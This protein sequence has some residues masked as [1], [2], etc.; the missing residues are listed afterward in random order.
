MTSAAA[1][2]KTVLVAADRVFVRDRF[3]TALETAGHQAVIVK[4]VAQ[5]LASVHADLDDLDLLVLDLRM[6]HASGVELI[7]RIR[8][9]DQGHLPILVFSGTVSSAEEVR[10][11]AALGVSGYLNEYAAVEHILPSIAPHLFPD[12]FNRRGGPRVVMGIPVSYRAGGTIAA[13]LS[14]NLSRGGIAIRTSAPLP[15]DTTLKLHFALPGSRKELETEGIVCWSHEKAGM[16]LRFTS[17]KPEDQADIND[18][19]DAHFFRDVNSR[20]TPE[21]S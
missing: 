8:K 3:R 6:Q 11:L 1:P 13:A 2:R 10:E 18:F 4:S 19:V 14:L 21:A 15:R 5:L 7:R 20:T 9:L 17:V 16:G 12:N